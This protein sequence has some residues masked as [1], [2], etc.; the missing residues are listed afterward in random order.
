MAATDDVTLACPL[1]SGNRASPMFEAGGHRYWKCAACALVFARGHTNANFRKYIDDYEPAYRQYLDEGPLDAL[2]LDAVIAWIESHVSL[3]DSAIRV[4]DVGAG[5]GKLVRGL[6]RVR[7][8]GVIG[9]EPSIA[10]FKTYNL[11]SLG[12]E[13][14]T[15]PELAL[16]QT[17]TYDVVTVFDV[18]E[19]V[20]E[21]AEFVNALSR[22]T[23][24]GSFVF[25]STPDS[26]GL[27]PR[28]LGRCWHHYNAYH[29]SLY[30]SQAIAEAARLGGFQIVSSGHRSKRMSLDYLWRRAMD[31]QLAGRS[32]SGAHHP[33]RFSIPVNLGDILSVVWQRS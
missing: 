5:S 10:L 16:R 27:L 18:I 19:H 33:S 13:A 4:L 8:C 15:L 24:P 20:P 9:I 11:A 14:I 23:R 7:P 32:K 29:F 26:Q 17:A 21:A 22:V 28:L 6:R 30:G 3:R 31:F 2:N 12:I 1:C 25:L